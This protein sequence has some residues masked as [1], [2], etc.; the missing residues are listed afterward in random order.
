MNYNPL[1]VRVLCYGDS[2][3]FGQLPDGSRKRYPLNVRWTGLLQNLLGDNYEIIEEGLPSRTADLDYAK[4][5][6]RNGKE[7]LPPIIASHNPLD[8]VILML[9][10]NDLKTEYQRTA[11]EITDALEGLI[12]DITDATLEYS[13]RPAKIILVSPAP[14]RM[15]NQDET[16]KLRGFYDLRSQEVSNG[17]AGTYKMLAERLQ[18]VYL[19]AG[20]I[21]EYVAEDGVHWQPEAH[22]LFAEKLAEVVRG[23]SS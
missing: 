13:S 8:I 19:D 18:L 11:Q 20:L 21:I 16:S 17:L 15:D 9:G 3:T 7:L 23:I 1:A 2:N 4:R 12:V 22:K 10:T 14:I 6:G 5:P